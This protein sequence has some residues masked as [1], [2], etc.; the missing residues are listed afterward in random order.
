MRPI[1]PRLDVGEEITVAENQLEYL[2]L[3]ATRVE[4]AD[5]DTQMVVRWTMTVEERSRIA[6]GEDVYICFPR[7]VFPHSVG[8]RPEWEIEK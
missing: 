6:S 2:T 5:G 8:L 7:N 1:A 4:F 3:V